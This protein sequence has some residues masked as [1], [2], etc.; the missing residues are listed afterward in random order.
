MVS[1]A[2]ATY[3]G[4]RFLKEQLD[5]ILEQTYNN[6]EIIV[7]DDC[8][9]DSTPRILE[10]YQK[11][12]SRLKI[13]INKKNL[14]FKKNFEKCISLCKGN[15][16][17]LSDQDDVW[18]KD[19]VECLVSNIGESDLICGNAYLVNTNLQDSGNNLYNLYDIDFLP[20]TKE[21]WFFYLIHHGIIQG[22]CTLFKKDLLQKALPIPDSV[23][24]HDYWLSLV[25]AANQGVKYLP[26]NCLLYYRQHENNVTENKKFS[27]SDRIK[28]AFNNESLKTK[29]EI[30]INILSEFLKIE[31]DSIKL[32]QIKK[33][34]LFYKRK[35]TLSRFLSIPY[36][37][38]N[39]KKIY[40]STNKKRFILRFVKF[41]VFGF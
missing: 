37:L 26:E 35:G 7:C 20:E 17:A 29:K 13:Y 18:T 8:S 12:D 30:Q 39:Y 21:D 36:F 34:L 4:E 24:F 10:E 22:A 19:H 5:S 1:I 11:K 31:T 16:I 14:G 2:L 9:T 32:N 6:I 3:N 15:F 27:F 40:L 41:F 28:K 38:K 23:K 33:A 25:A